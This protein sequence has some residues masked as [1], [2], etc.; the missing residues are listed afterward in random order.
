MTW[1]VL[2]CLNVVLIFLQIPSDE[3]LEEIF[4]KYKNEQWKFNLFHTL[5][6]LIAP[7]LEIVILLD[8]AAHL[9]KSG[10]CKSVEVRRAFDNTVSP[11]SYCI[12]AKK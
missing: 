8:I 3:S 2:I 6:L 11:R 12:I 5:R 9:E 1:F 10:C 4:N 7:F